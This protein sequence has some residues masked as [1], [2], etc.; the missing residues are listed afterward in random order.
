MDFT[1]YSAALQKYPIVRKRNWCAPRHSDASFEDEEFASS[2]PA[3]ISSLGSSNASSTSLSSSSS[4][5]KSASQI[6]GGDVWSMLESLGRL[7]YGLDAV[8]SKRFMRQCQDLHSKLLLGANIDDLDD[9]AATIRKTA[10][11]DR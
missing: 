1:E 10:E 5:T 7:H 9:L 3:S 11:G 2:A 6:T 4:S 8:E